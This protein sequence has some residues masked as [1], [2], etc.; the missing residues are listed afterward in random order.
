MDVIEREIDARE[1]S[2]VIS[3]QERKS[4]KV[5]THPTGTTRSFISHGKSKAVECYFCKKGHYASECKEVIDA[6][7][8][9]E[10]LKE[11][12][13]CFV[14]LKLGHIG[15]TCESGIRCKVCGKRHNQMICE[16]DKEKKGNEPKERPERNAVTMASKGNESVLLQTAQAMVYGED[17]SKQMRVN[18]LFDG[19]SQQSY[20]TEELRKKLG[21]KGEKKETVNFNTSGTDKRIKYNSELVQIKFEVDEEV[22]PIKALSFPTICSPIANRVS[23]RDHVHLAGLKLADS[24]NHNDKDIGILIGT[25][26]YFDFVTGD[27][28]KG[29]YGPIAVSSKLGWLLSIGTSII[30]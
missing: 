23:I 5:T 17:E 21:L 3:V 25:N 16:G 27:T 26:Y 8:R 29:S 2:R 15:K 19:G 24:C 13:M 30:S 10:I 22:V 6:Q 20:V 12:R 9:R 18:I 11:A 7:K 28:I 14:C 4:E 1:I